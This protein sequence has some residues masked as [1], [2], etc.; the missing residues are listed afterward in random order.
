MVESKIKTRD[1]LA[2]LCDYFRA[3]EL[4]IGFTS[5]AFDVLHA[6]HA[7]YLEKTKQYCDILIVGV[8]SDESVKR[9][10]GEDRPVIPE[11]HRIKLIAALQAVDFAFLFDERRNEKNIRALKPD[12]YFKAGDYSEN[13][14]TSKSVI[15]ES[16]G[17]VQLIPVAEDISTT[18]IIEK[19]Q[20]ATT[21][22]AHYKEEH[23]GT[24]F[25]EKK[26]MK[27]K[28]AI[29]LDRD[30]TI[31]KDTGYLSDPEQ[32][33][34][35]P[36]AIEGLKKLYD[37]EYRL[38]IITN[39]PGIGIGYYTREDFYRVNKRMLEGVSKH[40]IL[41]DKIYFCP[42]S[43]SENCNCRKPGTALVERAKQDMNLD[44][45]HSYFVGDS[46]GDI[47]AGKNAGLKTILVKSKFDPEKENEALES[48]PDFIVDNLLETA[49]LILKLERE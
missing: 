37:M 32:F 36:H 4:R 41:I 24:G 17:Q 42:H 12:F 43:K 45:A 49:E 27:K 18:L 16:G 5:G 3:E 6:G 40:H 47:A 22:H 9:Y 33:E 11:D 26:A 20:S 7:D 13:Q 2:E 25:F 46:W 31:N 39:Q 1:E 15:E 35:L 28:P 29:F 8:N 14:L 23:P 44:M 38:I 34:F 21:E 48:K 10:K 19:I 30:G